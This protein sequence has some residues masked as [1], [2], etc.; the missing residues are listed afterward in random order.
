MRLRDIYNHKKQPVISFE[1]FPPKT[2]EGLNN[3][4]SELQKLLVYKPGLISVTYG[5]GG[6]SQ[7]RSLLALERIAKEIPV[8]V[9]AHVTCIGSSTLS[10]AHFLQLIEAW[11]VDNILALR[12]DYPKNIPDYK[13]ESNVFK[14]AVDLVEFTK[15]KTQQDIAVAAFPEGHP[16]AV[17]LDS[18]IRYL[19]EKVA[20]GAQAVYTQ[21]FL[22]PEKF[23]RF[24]DRAVAAGVNVPIIPGIWTFST[25]EQL[26]KVPEI[27]PNA[28]IPEMLAACL[29][30]A[31]TEAEVKD[32]GVAYTVGMCEKLIA[33]GV[34]GLHL[35]C[36]N[37]AEIVSRVLD[38]LNLKK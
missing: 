23:L 8:S 19:V 25:K 31:K 12:G 9:M 1:V 37:K 28:N 36:L 34:A 38:S 13:P 35:Y 10:V 18:D 3:L 11:G 32:I 15:G 17:S 33:E 7:D 14:Y 22:T 20:A 30:A 24:R 29:R 27:A 6:T 5:A 2:P 26:N 4:I 21:L 16:E